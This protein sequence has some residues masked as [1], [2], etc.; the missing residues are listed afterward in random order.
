MK[1]TTDYMHKNILEPKSKIKYVHITIIILGIIFISIPIFH[2]NLW[3]DES[4]SVGIAS[5]S[6]ADIWNIGS[7]DVH[8]V[9][10]YW[11][12]HIFYLLFGSNLYIYR[13]ISMLPLAMLGIMGYTYVR[14]TFG[15][16]VGFLF[17][18]FVLFMPIS[19]VYAG[20]IR[21]YT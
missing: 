19:S 5:T 12:L 1:G 11:I 14:K 3:F 8:P 18:F 4:Y 6:F 16:K 20:E 7:N 10:Y 13:I 17:S 9:L 2:Q 21:M 15:E